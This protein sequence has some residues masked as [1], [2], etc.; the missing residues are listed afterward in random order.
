METNKEVNARNPSGSSRAKTLWKMTDAKYRGDPHNDQT[1]ATKVESAHIKS[2]T[3]AL[4]EA[5]RKVEI[6][7]DADFSAGGEQKLSSCESLLAR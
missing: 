6:W 7:E 2:P 5:L 4:S 1:Y 3:F